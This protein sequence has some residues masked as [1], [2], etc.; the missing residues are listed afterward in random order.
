VSL[1]AQCTVD[2]VCDDVS[3]LC[4]N[5]VCVCRLTHYDR[6]G[7]CGNYDVISICVLA[8]N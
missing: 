5:N 1:G 2:D 8:V 3:A 7:F 4:V 6:N